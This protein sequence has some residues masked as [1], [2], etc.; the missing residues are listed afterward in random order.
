MNEQEAKGVKSENEE[1]D[2]YDEFEERM[3]RIGLLIRSSWKVLTLDQRIAHIIALATLTFLVIYTRYTIKIYSG[4]QA[5][6]KLIRQQLVGTQAAALDYLTPTWQTEGE[7]GI[8][9]ATLINHGLISAQDVN[10]D[11]TVTRE[12]LSDFKPLESPI[13]FHKGPE[14]IKAGDR[15]T[16]ERHL[17]WKLEVIY[18]PKGPAY[19]LTDWPETWPGDETVEISGVFTYNNGF[20]DIITKRFCFRWLPMFSYSVGNRSQGIGGMPSCDDTLTTIK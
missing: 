20:D 8:I 12:R 2:A 4:N 10:F 14:T 1:K 15:A 16:V 17:P 9:S 5:Q 7:E 3:R 18:S 11:V 6:T 19:P 13:P